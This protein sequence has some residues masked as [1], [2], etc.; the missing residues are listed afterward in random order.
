MSAG[1]VA[2][3][4][5][6]A[7][8]GVDGDHALDRVLNHLRGAEDGVGGGFGGVDDGIHLVRS[9]HH[10]V[11]VGQRVLDRGDLDLR[12][13]DGSRH[14]ADLGADCVQTF[15]CGANFLIE[16]ALCL[17][18]RSIF[19]CLA[20][21]LALQLF[22]RLQQVC[23]RHAAVVGDRRYFGGPAALGGK[24][25]RPFARHISSLATPCAASLTASY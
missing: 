19:A 23:I 24:H 11:I 22:D 7:V 1:L 16:I 9:G 15:L 12:L 3:R 4:Q 17:G 13:L 25:P 8:F 18:C 10:L 5:Q 14:L 21:D 20:G 2:Q 6:V